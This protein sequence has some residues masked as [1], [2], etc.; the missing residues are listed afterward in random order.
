MWWCRR[1][2]L[3]TLLAA[4]LGGCGF[5]PLYASHRQSGFDEDLASI[6][7]STIP[8]RFG[9]LLAISLR[10]SLNPTGAQV[11]TRYGLDVTYSVE[12]SNLG[13]SSTGTATRGQATITANFVLRDL[14]ANKPVLQ[15]TTRAVSSFDV[16]SDDY[17]TV[18]AAQS[19]EERSLQDL[20]DE[21]RTRLSLY[22]KQ[23]RA[24][25][26]S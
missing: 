14:Q 12:R 15:G 8:G 9:Q 13:I 17:A 19:A 24:A 21:I 18:V 22:M 7:V 6:K 4:A 10:D 25:A 5:H 1:A 23:R 11:T 3:L 2:I 20:S 26:P 16:L